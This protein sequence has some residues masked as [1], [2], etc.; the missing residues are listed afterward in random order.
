VREKLQ[1]AFDAA[2]QYLGIAPL[3]DV[4]DIICGYIDERCTMYVLVLCSRLT[5]NCFGDV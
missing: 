5:A 2:E 1:S 3:M 4:D